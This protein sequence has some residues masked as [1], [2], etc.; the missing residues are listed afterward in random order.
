[1]SLEY[2]QIPIVDWTLAQRDKPLFLSQLR[3]AI[4]N[5]G[6]IYL[7]N[8]P[9]PMDL[10]DRVIDFT[11]KFFALPQAVKDSV[12]MKHS[13]HF[14][15]YL[16]VGGEA[17]DGNPDT[18]EQFNFGGDRVCRYEEGK[19]EY[20]KLH[21]NAL[22]PEDE[23][24]PGYRKTMLEYYKHLE[25][26]SYEFVGYVSEALGLEAHE[27]HALFGAD[28]SKLQPRCKLMR[29]PPSPPGT[30]GVG[31]GIGAHVDKSLLTYLLQAS[32]Q[33]GLEVMNHSGVWVPAP[34]IRGTLVINLGRALEKATHRVAIATRHR[35]VSPVEDARYSI[36]FFSSLAMHVRIADMN[37]DFPQEVLDMKKARD[38]RT[39][40]KT[41]SVQYTQYDHRLAGV[42]VLEEKIKTHPM[43]TLKFYPSLFD[44]F[45]PN[46]LP[47]HLRAH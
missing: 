24:L 29:Y 31:S 7:S 18:R 8:H 4:I 6:F 33:P 28:R 32:E 17:R 5:V 11:P 40:D 23:L 39:G 42:N 46:G 37:F 12:D 35:V 3:G 9:V 10:V 41:E 21:G 30:T 16:R 1:M 22:W 20:L 13:A 43:A 14:H 45:Y 19:P 38:E 47:A 34:P 36:G 25:D 44:K 15:G 2:T 27:L 26:L